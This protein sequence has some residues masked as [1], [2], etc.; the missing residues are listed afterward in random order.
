[1]ALRSSCRRSPNRGGLVDLREESALGYKRTAPRLLC[2]LG[3][4]PGCL[5]G[6]A[7]GTPRCR[8]GS[9][10]GRGTGPSV[11]G[12]ISGVEDAGVSEP[13]QLRVLMGLRWRD[14]KPESM[15]SLLLGASSTLSLKTLLTNI[16]ESMALCSGVMSAELGLL[17]GLMMVKL[18][19]SLSD[20]SSDSMRLC[21]CS[22]PA[23]DSSSG[24][25][26]QDAYTEGVAMAP[27]PPSIR[28][29]ATAIA[30]VST[31]RGTL[32]CLRADA[33]T[34]WCLSHSKECSVQ[35]E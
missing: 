27:L 29:L 17:L 33:A 16:I 32:Q 21:S 15:L 2:W 5:S 1:M 35:R 20:S 12:D 9:E 14:I 7:P 28:S 19:T 8:R 22:S 10:R 24:R 18:P 3:F 13:M 25:L 26:Q 31:L 4:F 6:D 30:T 23:I 11:S 34:S